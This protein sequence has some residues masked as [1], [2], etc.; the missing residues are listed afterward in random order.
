MSRGCLSSRH[1]VVMVW[2]RLGSSWRT[3]LQRALGRTAGL[4][5]TYEEQNEEDGY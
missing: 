3:L 2:D 5:G 1:S 4:K